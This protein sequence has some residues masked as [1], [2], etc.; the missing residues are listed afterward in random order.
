MS[1]WGFQLSKGLLGGPTLLGPIVVRGSASRCCRDGL[2]L[3]GSMKRTA[4][5]WQ[6]DQL[7]RNQG[8]WN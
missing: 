1:S 4:A 8:A 6:G 5:L 3:K 2:A 7:L